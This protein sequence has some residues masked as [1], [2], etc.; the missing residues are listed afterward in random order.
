METL[1][2]AKEVKA[3]KEHRCDFCCEKIRPGEVYTTSTHKQDGQIYD[4][5]SHKH[6]SEI[7]SRLKMYENCYDEGLTADSFQETIHC[8]YFDLMLSLFE[9]EDLKKYSDAIQQ[10]RQVLFRHKLMYVIRYYAKIDKSL[11]PQTQQ[12]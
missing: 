2:Y 7:A 1:S 9:K 10:F 5:K 3:A 8:Q 6:C 12:P 4:W 11:N